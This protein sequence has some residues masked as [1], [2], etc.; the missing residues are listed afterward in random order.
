MNHIIE[1]I[2]AWGVK[3]TPMPG[4]LQR[5][6][7]G[8]V[9]AFADKYRRYPVSHRH[10]RVSSVDR[11]S[12]LVNLVDG[13]GSAFICEN[14]SLS[15]SGGPFFALP[16]ECLEPAHIT[17]QVH[18]WNWGDNIPGAGQGVDYHIDRPVFDATAS[19]YDFQIRY[20]RNGEQN[21]RQGGEYKHHCID[22]SAELVRSW[23]SH[24]GI[25]A[26]LFRVA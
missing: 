5:V 19:P 15:I 1:T 6:H 16:I 3:S 25:T 12:G 23:P 11:E 14:G 8:D 26:Y 9:V 2:G 21:A 22:E 20:S 10:C 4:R 24:D 17:L 7:A 13:M 18:V